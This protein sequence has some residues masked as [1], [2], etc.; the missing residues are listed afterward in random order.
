MYIIGSVNNIGTSAEIVE[1][2]STIYTKNQPTSEA[3]IKNMVSIYGGVNEDYAILN[4]GN[5]VTSATNRIFKED[6]IFSLKW[7]PTSGI[8][9][10]DFSDYDTWKQ[11]DVSADTSSVSADGEDTAVLTWTIYDSDGIT[12]DSDFTS[13]F[14][15]DI[16]GTSADDKQHFLLN[17]SFTNGVATTNVNR[18][19]VSEWFL[20]S[21][22][23]TDRINRLKI[24][25][26]VQI[27]I[28]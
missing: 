2:G 14:D 6:A 8:S 26:R 12:L 9:G 27:L 15:V 17:L 16:I 13:V 23:F 7:T 22:R 19:Y 11:L 28:E 3:I 21:Y 18:N 10:V 4:F 25:N 24:K 20:P 1:K 5:E